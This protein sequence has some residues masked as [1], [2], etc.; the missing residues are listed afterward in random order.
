MKV[1]AGKFNLTE[2][3]KRAFGENPILAVKS[4]ILKG[5]VNINYLTLKKLS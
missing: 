3:G 2:L 1:R 5:I 4:N